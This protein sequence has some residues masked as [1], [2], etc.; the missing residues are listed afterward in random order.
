[1]SE[2]VRSCSVSFLHGV[3]GELGDRD[4]ALL[5]VTRRPAIWVSVYGVWLV[6]V[7]CFVA[8][9]Y[10]R[11]RTLAV[12]GVLG[13]FVVA[14][15]VL[16]RQACR[17]DGRRFVLAIP[18][19]IGIQAVLMAAISGGLHSPFA[20]VLLLTFSSMCAR[21]GGSRAGR[22]VVALFCGGVLWMALVPRS[23][24]GPP[25]PDPWL[26]V[27]ASVAAIGSLSVQAPFVRALRE[28]AAAAIDETLRARDELAHQALARARELEL[29]GAKLSHE[30]KNPLTA[31]KT[32]VQVAHRSSADPVVAK[33]LDVVE[34][35]IERMSFMLQGH[36]GFSRPG[37]LEPVEVELAEVA[38]SVMALLEGRANAAAV[39]LARKGSARATVDSK[40]IHG[41][42]LNLVANAIDA[43]ASGCRVEIALDED[44]GNVRVAIVDNGRGM[45]P[46]VVQRVGTPFFTTRECGTGLGVVLARAAFKQHGGTLEYQSAPG[47]GTTVLGTLP[48][49]SGASAAALGGRHYAPRHPLSSATVAGA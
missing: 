28:R 15:F 6:V 45:A 10:P 33:Q 19:V 47:Q 42:L 32:L 30:L 29:V 36:L 18:W 22:L 1:M 9:G 16:T 14:A 39:S 34:R 12:A 7:G 35:E 24:T 27:A 37:G 11:I 49:A 8:G 25:L 23:W 41:A 5:R 31:I 17:A 13:G 44:G 43:C 38:E 46:E 2:P 20:L 40:R 4:D 48:R 3:S 26:T 21:H